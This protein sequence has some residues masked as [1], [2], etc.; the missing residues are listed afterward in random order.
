MKQ[1]FGLLT[2]QENYC[3]YKRLHASNSPAM[4]NRPVTLIRWKRKTKKTT[5][6]HQCHTGQHCKTKPPTHA[7][8][9]SAACA[10]CQIQ[11]LSWNE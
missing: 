7:L 5:T 8:A 1:Q 2:K 4:A 3:G 11:Y 9:N 6:E 10:L